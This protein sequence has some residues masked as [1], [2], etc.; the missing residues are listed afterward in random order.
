MHNLFQFI[1][2]VLLIIL[3]TAKTWQG[4]SY[5]KI[6]KHFKATMI[7]F[8]GFTISKEPVPSTVASM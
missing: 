4:V 6:A 1:N 8:V 5:K 2:L 7:C 3:A